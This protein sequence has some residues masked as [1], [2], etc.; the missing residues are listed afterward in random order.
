MS[1]LFITLILSAT[2]FLLQRPQRAP[3]DMAR[4]HFLAP[5]YFYNSTPQIFASGAISS[6]FEQQISGS[7][8]KPSVLISENY[9]RTWLYLL[10]GMQTIN[11]LPLQLEQNMDR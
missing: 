6:Y 10:R 8:I 5:I 4:L 11:R 3:L 2:T 7:K 1:E 9:A